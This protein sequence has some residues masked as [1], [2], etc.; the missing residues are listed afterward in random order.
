MKGLLGGV[1]HIFTLP[2]I[3][4]GISKNDFLLLCGKES[5]VFILSNCPHGNVHSLILNVCQ[6]AK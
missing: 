1:N 3:E 2:R 4:M 6:F 5:F